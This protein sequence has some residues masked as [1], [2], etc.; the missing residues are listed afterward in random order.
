MAQIEEDN[1]KRELKLISR[2]SKQILLEINHKAGI[3]KRNSDRNLRN[4]KSK[5]KCSYPKSETN[6]DKR[7]SSDKKSKPYRNICTQRTHYMNKSESWNTNS[8][9]MFNF[10]QWLISP[11]QLMSIL[12]C[13]QDS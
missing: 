4:T 2:R 8:D 11:D 3:I 1:S 7:A 13:H 5:K 6:K 9:R 12:G 10:R